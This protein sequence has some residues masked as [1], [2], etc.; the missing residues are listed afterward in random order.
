LEDGMTQGRMHADEDVVSPALAARLV[1]AQFPQWSGLALRDT[2]SQ[3]SDNRLFRLGDGMVLRFPRNAAAAGMMKTEARWLPEIAPRL[4]LAVPVALAAGQADLC[5][6]HSWLVL[7]WI[8]GENAF[9]APPGD[10]LAGARQL[11]AFVAA[12]RAI[13]V[14]ED[15]PRMAESRH[16]R[17][18]D[19]FTRQMIARLTDEA[20][21][22]LVTR[23]WEDALHLPPWEGA[24]VLVHADLH[25]LNLLTRSGEIVAVID[26]GGFCAGDPAHDLICGW[27][28][29]QPAG[30]ALFRDLLGVDDATWARG[31]ALA[32]SKA[33]MA[34]P[35]Y[36]D[37]NPPLRDM[38]RA[39]L[40]QAIADWP[41]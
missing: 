24:P 25:P 26:W 28:V 5:Y 41:A 19:A 16:L 36:R 15:A 18:R 10:D 34:A 20:D 6:P 14:P 37:T 31:R 11:A 29:L 17:P 8:D 23:L 33:L 39:T 32:F 38:M 3:G 22:A 27:T 30:R 12:L 21:P 7:R 1:A 13:A 35:Y 40:T 9:T 4:P 2:G